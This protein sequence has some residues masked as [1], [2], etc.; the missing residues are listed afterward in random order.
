MSGMQTSNEARGAVADPVK[1]GQRGGSPV[2]SKQAGKKVN[3]VAKAAACARTVGPANTGEAR[4]SAED[5][6]TRRLSGSPAPPSP[7]EGG[8]GGAHEVVMSVAELAVMICEDPDNRKKR[9]KRAE[10]L[11]ERGLNESKLA[12][13]YSGVAEKLSRNKEQ[14]AVGVA[15]AK[16]LCDVLKELAH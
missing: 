2:T 16:L 10:A 6:L 7:Q 12:A 8:V 13:M 11:R 4:R 14:G 1:C 15:A 3:E 5:E 9:L